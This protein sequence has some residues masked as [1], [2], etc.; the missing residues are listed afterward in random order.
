[1]LRLILGGCGTG[2]STR[3]T[4]RIK[5]A[6]TAGKEVMVI[7]PEQ[8][9]FE[10]EKKLY[11]ALG[12]QLF[13]RIR[14]FSFT[15]LSRHILSLY[16]VHQRSYAGEQEKLLYLYHAVQKLSREGALTVFR[17]TSHSS[18]ALQSMMSLI[19]KIRKAGVSAQKMLDTA[20]LLPDQLADKT[21]DIGNILYAYDCI[22]EENGTHDG[23]V[24]LTEAA[25][26]AN[27]QDFFQDK[28]LFLD[29]FDSFTGDQYLMLDVMIAFADCVM[30]AIRTDE[31]DARI[32]PIFEGGNQ[33]RRQLRRIAE[34]D[35]HL[36]VEEEFCDTYCRSSAPDLTA[37]ST[38]IL[39]PA[40]ASSPYCG[41]VRIAEAPDAEAETEWICASICKMLS[42]H[43]D[44]RCRDIVIAVKELERYEGL[45][46]SAMKR[47]ALPFYLA[48]AKSILHTDLVQYLLSVLELLSEEEFSTE[49]LL[50]CL[51]S[52]FSGFRTVDVSMLEHY[53]FTWDIDGADWRS[54]FWEEDSLLA[55][56][57]MEFGGKFLENTRKTAIDEFIKLKRQCKGKSV[58][59][60]CLHLYQHLLRKKSAYEPVLMQRDA[61]QQREFAALWNLSMDVL[62]TIVHCLG[63]EMLEPKAIYDIAVLLCQTS[64]FSTPPQT[65]DSIQIVSAQSA[66]LDSPKVVFVPGAVE[67]A[68]PGEISVS[69]VFSQ[70]EL[71]QLSEQG[72]ALSR[73]FFE[74]YSDERLI[75]SKILSAPTQ[76]LALSYPLRGEGEFTAPSPVIQ[77]ILR[78][79][80]DALVL[81]KTEE[82]PLS[83]YAWT[84]AS[85]YYHFVR[86]LQN[87]SPELASMQLLLDRDPLYAAKTAK[88][89]DGGTL[90]DHPVPA[91]LMQKFLG[92]RLL[93]SPSGIETFYRCPYQY[94]TGYCLRLYVPEK[95]ELSSLNLGNFAHYCFEQILQDYPGEQFTRLTEEQLTAEIGRLSASFS[96]SA[97]SDSV[98]RDSRFQTNYRMA[99]MSLLQV[100]LHMQREMRESAFAPIGFEVQMGSGEQAQIPPLLLRDG[101]IECGGKIDR[102]DLCQTPDG[103]IVRVIDYKTG[104]KLFSPEKLAHGL[105]MQMLIYLFA[106]QGSEEFQNC[107]PGGVL[108]MPSGQLQFKHYEE[109]NSKTTSPDRVLNDFYCM[110]GLLHEKAAPHMEPEIAQGCTPVLTQNGEF[111]LFSV[112]SEQ[113]E[114]LRCHVM[115]RIANMADQLYAGDILPAPYL[116]FPCSYCKCKDMCHR[117]PAPAESLSDDE[118]YDAITKVFGTAEEVEE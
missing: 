112:S 91:A 39:R 117:P 54:P 92:D 98:R 26:I 45:F 81:E 52:P 65:L 90:E 99:G 66:R 86:N 95:R 19:T 118:K 104:T 8:F 6:V 82:F 2:K 28:V 4:E 32:S 21:R 34:Q 60:L 63:S 12:A 23:L 46:L 41:N 16:G 108:Y 36:E 88:L 58:S 20:A 101:A 78:M 31:P 111:S 72:I 79:F 1:M 29:E 27:I 73:M 116:N 53:A 68:F 100:L 13:N 64:S 83:Y 3:I 37:V 61:L 14:T 105:D 106:L 17:R 40:A 48:K 56:Q 18:D 77:Q 38:K 89:A 10:A 22:L 15:T 71:E 25:A 109:R 35:H 5:D 69:G 9:S 94:F 93:L 33:T 84:H 113:M 97:F 114:K 50:R 59:E 76:H 96:E 49:A 57:S 62:D 75:V 11:E 7:V 87:D 51:K 43:P 70:Q 102:I 30:A 115:E 103:S 55:D 44:L 110:K 74:L 47:Y 24:D 107:D 42:E 67:N 80:G 85:M